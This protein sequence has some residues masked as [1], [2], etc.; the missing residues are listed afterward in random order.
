[1][2]SYSV[3]DL[4]PLTLT[5]LAHRWRGRRAAW[6]T[7]VV[8]VPYGAPGDEIEVRLCDVRKNYARGE[9]NRIIKSSPHRVSPA[10]PNLLQVRRL[11]APADDLQVTNRI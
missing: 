3:G 6:K 10:V 11:S 1:M 5:G 8:F 2:S 7:L 9:I 4:Y